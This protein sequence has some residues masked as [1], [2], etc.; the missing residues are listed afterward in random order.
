MYFV[1]MM[2]NSINKLYVGITQNPDA[3]ARHHNEQRGAKFTK[4]KTDFGI[5]FL[6]KYTTLAEARKRE[7]QIKKWRREKKE[8]LIERYSQ[9]LPT[10]MSQVSKE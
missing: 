4:Y 3:R 1:Y 9:G 7:I 2:K 10:K 5:V 6:E 8:N